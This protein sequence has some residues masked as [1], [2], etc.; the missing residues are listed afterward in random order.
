MYI[1]RIWLACI[2][3]TLTTAVLAAS[4]TPPKTPNPLD[5]K[6]MAAALRTA[7][8][9]ED[10]FIA[11]VLARVDAGSLPLDLVE[12]T[13]LWARKKPHNKFQYFKRGLIYRAQQQ[14]ICLKSNPSSSA[15]SRPST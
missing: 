11:Y 2:V 8:P 10:G 3:L 9:E 1:K 5:A 12:S 15:A 6:T 13:F 4:K 14:G 7:A